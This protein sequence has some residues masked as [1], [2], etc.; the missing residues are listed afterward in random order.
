MAMLPKEVNIFD[1]LCPRS[2]QF[3]PNIVCILILILAGLI[4]LLFLLLVGELYSLRSWYNLNVW[5]NEGDWRVQDMNLS[6]WESFDS[7]INPIENERVMIIMEQISDID[8]DIEQIHSV[9]VVPS[10]VDVVFIAE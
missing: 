6:S 2:Q 7:F 5:V 10:E 9:H 8:I 3:H 4:R 1:D